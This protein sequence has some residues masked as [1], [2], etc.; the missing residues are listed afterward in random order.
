MLYIA[1]EVVA[2]AKEMDLLTYLR[3]FE[4]EE[5]VH[6]GGDTYCTREHDSLKIS[7]GKWHWFSHR[8]GGKTA[9]DYLIKVK[10]MPFL[11]AVKHL[12]GQTA[13]MPVPQS[14]P[15]KPK[16]PSEKVLLLPKPNRSGHH[17]INYLQ[18]RGI[19][20]ELIDFCLRTGR[21]YESY[22]PPQCGFRGS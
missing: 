4:P 3:S 20:S 18:S 10:R 11:E 19:D 15:Q 2:K 17:V 14:A 1:H 8:I 5:L 6:F 7:N 13:V 9:L 12:T 21:L 16:A 22:P